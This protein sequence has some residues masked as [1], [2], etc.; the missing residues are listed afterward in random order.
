MWSSGD[1]R[2]CCFGQGLVS[3]KRFWARILKTPK[4][5]FFYMNFFTFFFCWGGCP[6]SRG[7][8]IYKF[9]HVIPTLTHFWARVRHFSRLTRLDREALEGKNEKSF[10]SVIFYFFSNIFFCILH[11]EL[12]GQT[13]ML[14]WAGSGEPKKVLGTDFQNKK[15]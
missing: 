12:W 9:G 11:V 4:F 1:K 6:S 5:W 13:I 15:S 7:A 3:L 8:R 10:F 14:L 2:L